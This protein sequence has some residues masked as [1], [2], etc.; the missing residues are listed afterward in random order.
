VRSKASK[1][2]NTKILSLPLREGQGISFGSA[3]TGKTIIGTKA[4]TEKIK[5]RV[6]F[7]PHSTWKKIRIPKNEMNNPTQLI[8]K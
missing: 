6:S 8:P 5:N 2:I 1:P 4:Q 3:K 7:R